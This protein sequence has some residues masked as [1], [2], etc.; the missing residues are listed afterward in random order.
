[1][2]LLLL[3]FLTKTI[4]PLSCFLP[5][6]DLSVGEVFARKDGK[7]FMFFFSSWNHLHNFTKKAGNTALEAGGSVCLQCHP[8]GCRVVNP[9]LWY[10]THC[11]RAA[12]VFNVQHRKQNHPQTIRDAVTW[13][14]KVNHDKSELLIASLKEPNQYKFQITL[15]EEVTLN[16][17]S[18][19]TT[20]R[21]ARCQVESLLKGPQCYFSW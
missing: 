5:I 15:C 21:M 7:A 14:K 20:L 17:L 1:M 4:K 6:S 13:K 8:E 19:A 9:W 2:Q 10:W 12:S 16:K 18:L 11:F 3:T